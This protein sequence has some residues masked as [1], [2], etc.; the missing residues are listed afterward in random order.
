MK[1][2]TLTNK[3]RRKE[4]RGDCTISLMTTGLLEYLMEHFELALSFTEQELIETIHFKESQEE[5][6]NL[7]PEAEKA[8]Y[9][10][11]ENMGE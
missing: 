4:Y 8:G 7:L 3:T 2:I 5:V 10:T 1:K 6:L 9:L 11:I